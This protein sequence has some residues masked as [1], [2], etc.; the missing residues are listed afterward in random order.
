VEGSRERLGIAVRD[1]HGCTNNVI[2]WGIGSENDQRL[3]GF[4]ADTGATI[5]AGGH[6]NE[7]MAGTRR[8]NTGIVARGRIY[9]ANDNKVFAFR[10]PGQTVNTL[11]LTNLNVSV[12]GVF[13]FGFT[14]TPGALFNAFGSTSLA[15]PMSNWTWLG[16]VPS[17]RRALSFFQPD[18]CDE[19]G[20]FLSR[21][22]AVIK[23]TRAHSGSGWPPINTGTGWVDRCKTG[24]RGALRSSRPERG[25]QTSS[26]CVKT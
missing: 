13:R 19:P 4:N 6:A 2:V 26:I 22:F 5:F 25:S 16:E 9:V 7:L 1:D 20:R 24:H 8:F 15:S 11:A 10:V 23:R 12:G 17:F 21:H 3:H 14:N 18:Q